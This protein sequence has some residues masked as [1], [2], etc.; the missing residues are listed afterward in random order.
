MKYTYNKLV[1][2]KIVE[3]IKNSDRNP[4]YRIMD[5]EEYLKELNKK[6]LEEAHEFVEEN[7]IE[8]L[9]DVFEVIESIIKIKN[10][11]IEEVRKYQQIKKEKNGGFD[12]K[13]YLINVEQDNIDE[14]EEKELKKDW[15]N[16]L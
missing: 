1:R 5:N 16:R 6:L 12:K 9:A 14:K 13:I 15:R 4:S 3:N 10:I 7:S 11:N 2:D 8:E